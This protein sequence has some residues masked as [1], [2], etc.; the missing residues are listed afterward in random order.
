MRVLV[1]GGAGFIGSHVAERLFVVERPV[2]T[3]ERN[4]RGTEHVL[5]AALAHG[6]RMPDLDKRRALV[7]D[8]PECSLDDILRDMVEDGRRCL[9]R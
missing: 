2:D 9:G 4:V 1:T 7:G 5:E 3:I 6:C 8:R